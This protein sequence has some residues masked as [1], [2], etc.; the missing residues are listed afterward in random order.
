MSIPSRID[1]VSTQALK[2]VDLADTD[3]MTRLTP[4]I[5]EALKAEVKSQC[6]KH[7]EEDYPAHLRKKIINNA[8]ADKVDVS[9]ALSSAIRKLRLDRDA[10]RELTH[11]A[12]DRLSVIDT[13]AEQALNTEYIPSVSIDEFDGVFDEAVVIRFEKT[14]DKRNGFFKIEIAQDFVDRCNEDKFDVNDKIQKAAKDWVNGNIRRVRSTIASIFSCV[15][16]PIST[17]S[18]NGIPAIV[19]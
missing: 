12:R 14:L 13:D 8:K 16:Q 15:L 18:G 17:Q 5:K 2:A 9:A 3:K 10:G 7:V 11:H 19:E 6:V 1:A 4:E